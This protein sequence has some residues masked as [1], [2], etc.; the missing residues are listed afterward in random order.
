MYNLSAMQQRNVLNRKNNYNNN[1]CSRTL[2]VFVHHYN[3]FILLT[4]AVCVLFI[5]II[6]FILL[7]HSVCVS[8]GGGGGGGG[9]G[10]GWGGV[11]WGGCYINI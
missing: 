6:F 7:T 4:H 10:V 1:F 5:I 11:G 9:V 2:F 3:L 8:G